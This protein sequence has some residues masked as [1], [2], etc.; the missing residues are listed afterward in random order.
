LT[1][2]PAVFS[3]TLFE[4]ILIYC[5]FEIIIDQISFPLH[6]LKVLT[7]LFER[8]KIGLTCFGGR[9]L[10]PGEEFGTPARSKMLCGPGSR[11]LKKCFLTPI[12]LPGFC[13][14][15]VLKKHSR[16]NLAR[17]G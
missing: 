7:R 11:F 14:K 6:R 16:R 8:M 12:F 4:N 17:K 10:K 3:K 2:R 13:R 15:T 9:G 1:C 5:L